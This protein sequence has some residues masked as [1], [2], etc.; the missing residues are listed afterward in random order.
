MRGD[1][2]LP[3]NDAGL[4]VE[5][6]TGH[7][8]LR[9]SCA[10]PGQLTKK[11]LGLPHVNEP[12]NAKSRMACAG[13][14]E[15]EQYNGGSAFKLT[16]RDASGVIVTLIA[17]NYFGYCKKE[18]KTQ[19][20]F[21]ANLLGFAKKSM[22]EERWFIRVM[23]WVRNSA[24]ICMS[25]GLGHSFHEVLKLYEPFMELKPEGYAVDRQHPDII[26]VP[27]DVHFDLA[28]QTVSWA[29]PEGKKSIRLLAGKMYV[30]PS[31]YKV[32]MEKIP[33]TKAWRLVGTVAEGLFATN[34]ALCQVVA[35][36]KFPNR[37][38]TPSFKARYSLL[39]LEV[40]LT[41][42]QN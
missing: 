40:T 36:R 32:H 10:A 7:D 5:H 38:A 27:E 15:D 41:R 24:D 26:Y 37:S 25:G 23:I 42:S 6:W 29:S 35:N 19:I 2:F 34:R 11:E 31:G 16:C 8:R 13:S 28:G 14:E 17:D 4:D 33:G 30:R 20:S 21:S 1:P 39:I 18:V 22:P 3:E 12:P 9:H